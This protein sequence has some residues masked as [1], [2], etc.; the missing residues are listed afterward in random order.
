MTFFMDM[1]LRSD[2]EFIIGG[3]SEEELADFNAVLR[4]I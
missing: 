1:M 3:L 4:V 2:G